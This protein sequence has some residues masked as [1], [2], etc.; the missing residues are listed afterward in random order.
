MPPRA[1]ACQVCTHDKRAS[2]ELGLTYGT[3]LR[4]LSQR[5]EVSKDALHQHR[6]KHLSP[7]LQAALLAKQ[8]AQ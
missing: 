3:P 2:I 7:Q 6:H 5:F 8:E 4:V 1:S